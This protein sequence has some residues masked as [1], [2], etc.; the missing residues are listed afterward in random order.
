MITGQLKTDY[1]KS[2]LA[3]MAIPIKLRGET[4]GIVN[5]R[6]SLMRPWD[7]DEVDIA[8]AAADRVALTL[9]NARLLS[10]AQR[11]A[12]KE[13]TI[14]EISTRI[15]SLVDIDNILQTAAREMS[16]MLP[17]SEVVIQLQKK[18]QGGGE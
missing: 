10:T 1:D 17:G 15:G 8:Q 9:E 3:K 4:I 13:R 6:S 11:R 18:E 2:G 7:Q 12:A 14:G 5:V 16:Q